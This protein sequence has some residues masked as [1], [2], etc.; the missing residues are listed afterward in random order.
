[1]S[2]VPDH[3]V[4]PTLRGHIY[5][6][7]VYNVSRKQFVIQGEPAMVEMARRL[8]PGARVARGLLSFSDTRRAAGDLNWF[9]LRFPLD[10]LCPAELEA[11]RGRAIEHALRRSENADLKPA[12]IPPEFTGKLFPYQSV[13]ARFLVANERTLLADAQGLGKTWTALAAAALRGKYPVLIVCPPQ[14]M[15]QW[16]RAIG[17]LL[18]LPG[19]PFQLRLDDTPWDVSVR[20][21]ASLSP[22]LRTRT[23]YALPSAPFA[24][25]HYGLIDAWREVL[26]ARGFQAIVFDEAQELRHR[27]SAK[28]AAASV[29][30]SAVDCVWGLSGTPI[31]G[32]GA[33]IW[34]VLNAV[35]FQCLGAAD[36]FT[37]EWCTGRGDHIVDHPEILGDHL[38]REGLM[39]RRRTSEVQ[40][41]LPPILRRIQDVD[42]DEGV[43]AALIREAVQQ[44]HEFNQMAWFKRGQAARD[45]DRRSRHAAGVAKAHFVGAFIAGLVS[46]GERPLVFAWHHDVHDILK[47]TLAAHNP[48]VLTGRETEAQKERDLMRF[49]NGDTDVALLSLRTVAGMD[50]LQ[51]RATCTVMAELDWSPAVHSQC[52]TRAARLGI[53]NSVENI[54]SYYCAAQTGYDQVMLDVLG[55]KTSQFLGIMGDE[56]ETAEERMAQDEAVARRI[57]TLVERLSGQAVNADTMSPGGLVE[58]ARCL[59]E[60]P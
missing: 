32:Y 25:I 10:V 51:A 7:M 22:I 27:A 18:D 29:L 12:D 36:A 54:P 56:P 58:V 59:K 41:D 33:E 24:I 15:R 28:Y 6:K 16:Q 38:R 49:I 43:H 42:H 39:L 9:L 13:G 1:M 11:A 55:L 20:R 50:G 14:V 40:P 2:Y 48:S 3:L 57:L 34:N 47:E 21:G 8:F 37:R 52:E 46:A 35:D 26:V 60:D 5:G 45:I 30:S 44:A 19:T 53:P 4:E 23:P 17:A 31:Y